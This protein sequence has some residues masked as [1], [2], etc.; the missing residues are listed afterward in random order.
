VLPNGLSMSGNDQITIAPGGS[1][2]C[3]AAALP[4]PLAATV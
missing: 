2:K 4:A 1:L 3:F